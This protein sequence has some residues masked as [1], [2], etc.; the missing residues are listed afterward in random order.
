MSEEVNLIKI[1]ST[2]FHM[3]ISIRDV[4]EKHNI[5]YMIA[6]GTLLGAVR[7]NNFIPWDDDFDFYLFDDSYDIAIKYLRLELPSD[8]F[9][10]DENTEPLYFHGWAHVKDLHSIAECDEF[11]QDNLYSHKG[12]SVDLYRTKQ[13]KKKEVEEYLNNQNE[14]YINR[15]RNKGLMS[16]QEYELRCEKL[17]ERRKVEHQYVDG[18]Q[19]VYNLISFYNCYYMKANDIFPLKPYSFNNEIFS[20]PANAHNILTDIYGDYMVLPPE[21]K[22]KSHYSSVKFIDRDFE[23]V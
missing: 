14:L 19:I 5:P 1:Q 4:L 21:V 11:P 9:V 2:L 7:H 15:R 22:R 12:I 10:E 3:A 20:G 13:M 17:R 18:E 8:L 23:E 6:Y 16:N